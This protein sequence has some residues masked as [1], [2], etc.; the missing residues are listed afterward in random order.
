MSEQSMQ[1]VFVPGQMEVDPV[2]GKI[3]SF[4][5]AVPDVT[6]DFYDQPTVGELIREQN[7]VPMT[8]SEIFGKSSEL[9][10]SEEDRQNFCHAVEEAKR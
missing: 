5:L 10:E 1:H 3:I 9:F 2:T 8:L 6:G 4:H 7:Y